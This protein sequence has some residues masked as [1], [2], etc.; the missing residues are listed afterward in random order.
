MKSNSIYYFVLFTLF[1]VIFSLYY[2]LKIDE[3]NYFLFA[4]IGAINL[5]VLYVWVYYFRNRMNLKLLESAEY[6]KNRTLQITKNIL[7]GLIV[8]IIG[9]WLVAYFNL[10]NLQNYK[11]DFQTVLVIQLIILF[12]II[13]YESH[14]KLKE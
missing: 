7:R 11:S 10:A 12:G 8:V 1:I 13:V 2:V 3:P 5:S 9:L 14:T 6:P 4:A